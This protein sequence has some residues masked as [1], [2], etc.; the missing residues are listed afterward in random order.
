[1]DEGNSSAPGPWHTVPIEE[2]TLPPDGR[3]NLVKKRWK[4]LRQRFSGEDGEAEVFRAEADLRELPNARLAHI[5]P[6]IDWSS[7]AR[8]LAQAFS[9]VTQG[10]ILKPGARS[11]KSEDAT[12]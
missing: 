6:P 4:A 2:Y 10:G 11:S 5:V 8:S 7:A 1:M 12:P 9:E 3:T